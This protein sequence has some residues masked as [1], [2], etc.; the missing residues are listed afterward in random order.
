MVTCQEWVFEISNLKTELQTT[1]V[2]STYN[3]EI[4]I[5]HQKLV[6]SSKILQNHMP[7]ISSH[8][9]T[10]NCITIPLCTC[11]GLQATIKISIVR[12]LFL[13]WP[14][15]VTSGQQEK[16]NL[17]LC[18]KETKRGVSF[19]AECQQTG[20]KKPASVKARG[21]RQVSK[22][23]ETGKCQSVCTLSQC[24]KNR[25]YQKKVVFKKR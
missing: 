11:S 13:E 17:Q 2:Q 16:R 22:R 14:S 19:L 7:Q 23:V 4:I 5:Q 24:D 25:C 12:L 21:N 20:V 18:E 6:S 8:N 9:L 3:L 10:G 15:R 1:I